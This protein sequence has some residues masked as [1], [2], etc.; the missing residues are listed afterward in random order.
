MGGTGLHLHR[1]DASHLTPPSPDLLYLQWGQHGGTIY[2]SVGS[3]HMESWVGTQSQSS[4]TSTARCSL[5]MTG[6]SSLVSV[7]SGS[8]AARAGWEGWSRTSRGQQDEGRELPLR[9]SWGWR[10]KKVCCPQACA[11]VE[12]MGWRGP[13]GSD[14]D[15]VS[16]SRPRLCEHQ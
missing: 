11:L 6:Q 12:V 5:L 13:P 16:C 4:S 9:P 8:L 1:E 14:R 7:G 2:P 10:P 3:E 15:N